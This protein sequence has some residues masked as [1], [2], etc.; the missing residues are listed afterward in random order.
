MGTCAAVL[1]SFP[2]DDQQRMGQFA[3][4]DV[5]GQ[6]QPVLEAV[7]GEAS[8]GVVISGRF[9]P[10]YEQR[11]KPRP[12]RLRGTR[13]S[14]RSPPLSRRSHAS[15]HGHCSGSREYP[16]G[17]GP[18][19]IWTFCKRRSKTAAPSDYIPPCNAGRQELSCN[20]QRLRD[21]ASSKLTRPLERLIL[22]MR[23]GRQ[24][25]G[26]VPEI[27]CIIAGHSEHISRANDC[28]AGA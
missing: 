1:V 15:F 23:L 17:S 12:A 11:M 5:V 21:P 7:R 8:A 24:I 19:G 3:F 4:D 16:G 20:N 22:T 25:L 9:V 26:G 18:S 28:A 27:S 10:V 14:L 6:A 2:V 13:R